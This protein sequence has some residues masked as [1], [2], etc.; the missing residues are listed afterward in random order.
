MWGNPWGFESPPEHH[1]LAPLHR[2]GLPHGA[3]AVDGSDPERHN[4]GM[5]SFLPLC[6]RA[7]RRLHGLPPAETTPLYLPPEAQMDVQV[8]AQRHRVLGLLQAGL[9]DA[10]AGMRSAA[11][12]KTRHAVQTTVEAERLHALLSPALPGLAIV[13]GPA[14]AAQAWPQPGLRNFDDLD[15]LCARPDYPRLLGGMR[16]AGYAPATDDPR[17]MELLWHYGWG[18]SFRHPDGFLV[19][20]NHRF[21]PPHYPW[22]RRIRVSGPDGFALQPLDT[23]AVRAPTP[24]LHLLLGCE[25]A[26]WHGWERL[27]WIADVAGLLA[28]HPDIFAQAMALARGCPFAERA[29]G[30]GCAVAE[31]IFGPGLG[32]AG[33]TFPDDVAL[34][35]ALLDGPTRSIKG[36]ERRKF[37]ERFMTPGEILAYRLRRTFTPGDGDFRRLSLPPAWRGLYWLF[38]PARGARFGP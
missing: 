24:A 11:Y 13:K 9:P 15:F 10:P 32:P 28:R 21:F 12:G 29:L 26:I 7:F 27:A 1:S 36:R 23:A 31:G 16:Q 5:D 33:R 19:E 35:I 4:T 6:R 2:S 38:R 25:H 14:L 8:L 17:R 3:L 34:A 18:I 22:P 30:V 37:H 20:V